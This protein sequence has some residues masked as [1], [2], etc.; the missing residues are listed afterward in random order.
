MW[1]T[2]DWKAKNKWTQ[3]YAARVNKINLPYLKFIKVDAHTGVIYNE[4]ADIFARVGCGMLD[5]EGLIRSLERY[6]TRLT[7]EVFIL[8]KNKPNY[9]LVLPFNELEF[10]TLEIENDQNSAI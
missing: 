2:G 1:V 10:I 8:I 6:N 7:G 9:N 5:K 4:L 3:Q